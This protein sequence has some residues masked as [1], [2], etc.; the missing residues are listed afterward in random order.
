[1][2]ISRIKDYTD[3]DLDF[4]AHPITGDVTKKV[5]PDAIAR[6]IRNLVMTNYY[7]RPFRSQIGSNALKMLFE[8]IGPLTAI[9]LEQAIS[10]VVTNF[11]PRAK[12]IGVKVKA[13]PDNN[14]YS[15]K[16]AFY[17]KNRP[18]PFQTTLF[19]ERIR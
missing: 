6:S 18:E 19:L 14:G 4:I 11:E 12:L 16:I 2:A 15:A 3:L 5:G 7:D 8:N 10:D 1:M 9:N 17:V 13:D